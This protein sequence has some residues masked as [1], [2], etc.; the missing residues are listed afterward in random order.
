MRCIALAQRWHQS[1][2]R[3]IF[4]QAFST[5]AVTDRLQ[6][7]GLEVL[8]IDCEAGSPADAAQTSTY[9]KR[10]GAFWVV[11][12]GYDFGSEWQLKVTQSGSR[13]L[14][15]DDYGHSKF[16]YADLVLN[17][18]VGVDDMLYSL[19]DVSTQLLLGP[20]YVLLR[21]EFSDWRDFKR[22]FPSKGTKVLVTLGGSDPDNVTAKVIEALRLIPSIE[23]TII[24]GGSNPH[25]SVIRHT[26]GE[27]S[28]SLRVVV[29]P[30]SMPEL[31]AWADVGISAA[32][33]T[34]WELAF[35]GLPSLLIVTAENQRYVAATLD[36]AK[37]GVNLGFHRELTADGITAV[38]VPL[39]GD[40]LRRKALSANGQKLVDGLGVW[41]V[42]SVLFA[43]PNIL[44]MSDSESGLRGYLGD[45]KGLLEKAASALK[46]YRP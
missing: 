30:S 28:S 32:G 18:N 14:I 10:L 21:K 7:E 36:R 45:T 17:Q 26:L 2:G 40:S 9:A 20:R 43:T 24:V 11:A 31:I 42:L 19:R 44:I 1:G 34:S 3:V 22:S 35:M 13:L 25:L 6:S 15:V 8:A 29:N 41:R 23:A 4:V 39:L 16:Y 37:A 5:S 12:D 38:L 46:E 33:S 27:I